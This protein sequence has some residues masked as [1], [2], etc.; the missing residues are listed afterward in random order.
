MG[1][2]IMKTGLMSIAIIF[3]AD[4]LSS[5]AAYV[6]QGISPDLAIEHVLSSTKKT[7]PEIKPKSGG[8]LK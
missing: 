6:E 2:N 3:S 1:T 5:I 4:Q 7:P 8:K